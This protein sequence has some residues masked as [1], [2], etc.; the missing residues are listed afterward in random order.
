[1]NDAEYEQQKTRVQRLIAKWTADLGLNTWQI[2]YEWS[3]E[4]LRPIEGGLSTSDKF[5]PVMI[6]EAHW[7]YLLAT[8]EVCLPEVMDVDDWHLEQYLVHE[9]AHILLNEMH[10]WH[11]EE[12]QW[13]EER[14][15]TYLARAFMW[16]YEA[17][18]NSVL[19]EGPQGA[20]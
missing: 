8:I 10:A 1:M 19:P 14:V 2:R 17:G 5:G 6:C 20:D 9:Y 4:S 13:H 15:A 12:G 16:V 3:R 11:H 7:P 18:R